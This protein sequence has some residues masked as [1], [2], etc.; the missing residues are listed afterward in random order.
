MATSRTFKSGMVSDASIPPFINESKSDTGWTCTFDT[1]L[2]KFIGALHVRFQAACSN[3]SVIQKIGGVSIGMITTLPVQSGVT[4]YMI[5][6]AITS[7]GT[8]SVEITPDT[9]ATPS[10]TKYDLVGINYN[11]E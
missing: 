3:V 8:F 9:V 1:E 10:N 6:V 11:E 2:G 7:G 4:H 5:P